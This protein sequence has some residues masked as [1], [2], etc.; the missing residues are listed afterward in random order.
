[1]IDQEKKFCVGCERALSPPI[2]MNWGGEKMYE[3]KDGFYC[4]KC[5]K[6]RVDKVRK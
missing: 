1:M 2:I 6:I 4:E 3:F 5:A